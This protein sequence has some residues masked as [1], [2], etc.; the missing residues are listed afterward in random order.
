MSVAFSCKREAQAVGC[1]WREKG[2]SEH[3][4][5]HEGWL[6]RLVPTAG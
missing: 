4:R 6:S 3:G 2:I 5:A 1:L